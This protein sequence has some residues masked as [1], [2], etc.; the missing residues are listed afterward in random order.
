MAEVITESLQQSM[1]E[2][3]ASWKEDLG[4]QGFRPLEGVWIPQYRVRG[5]GDPFDEAEEFRALQ[6]AVARKSPQARGPPVGARKGPAGP[7]GVRAGS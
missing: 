2:F 3:E 1:D 5:E 4:G 7:D 6:S